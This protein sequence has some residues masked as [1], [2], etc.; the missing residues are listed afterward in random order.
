MI[1][2]CGSLDLEGVNN[3]F[4]TQNNCYPSCLCKLLNGNRLG[5]CP[6]D[7]GVMLKS[8]PCHKEMNIMFEIFKN[9]FSH[10]L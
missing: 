5:Y 4:V 8:N 7:I 1:R 10:K 6:M 2:F 3:S 9:V